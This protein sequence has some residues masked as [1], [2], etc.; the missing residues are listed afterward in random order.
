MQAQIKRETE[1]RQ[2]QLEQ[3]RQR[4]QEENRKRAQETRINL[5]L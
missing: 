5:K 4:T 2:R 3:I 1:D